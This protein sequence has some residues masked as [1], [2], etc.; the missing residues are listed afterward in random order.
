MRR[1]HG[2]AQGLRPDEPYA[3]DVSDEC[4]QGLRARG[5]KSRMRRMNQVVH[6]GPHIRAKDHTNWL[7]PDIRG[8]APGLDEPVEEAAQPPTGAPRIA[9]YPPPKIYPLHS[10]DTF[11]AL[12]HEGKIFMGGRPKGR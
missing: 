5:R 12:S 2:C 6:L 7:L 11:V 4:A 9:L 1:M 8:Q 3:T 10:T